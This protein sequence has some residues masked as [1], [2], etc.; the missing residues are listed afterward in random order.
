MLSSMSWNISGG[1]LSYYHHLFSTAVREKGG[2]K[3]GVEEQKGCL[4]RV[5]HGTNDDKD[6]ST[7]AFGFVQSTL[8]T[9]TE[10]SKVS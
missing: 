2:E 10:R 4:G 8:V 7:C 1:Y 6:S 3:A 9:K 5:Q